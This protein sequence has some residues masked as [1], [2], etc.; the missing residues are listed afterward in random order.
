MPYIPQEQRSTIDTAVKR[1]AEAIRE[2]AGSDQHL[3]GCAGLINYAVT[4]LVLELLKT[5]GCMRYHH[6]ALVTG[7]LENIKQ[8]FYRRAAGPYE[9]KKAQENGDVYVFG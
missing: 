2:A 9:D 3:Q 8:E 7:V 6:I 1:L 4:C 5:E